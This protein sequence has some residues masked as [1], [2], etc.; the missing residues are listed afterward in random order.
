MALFQK[1]KKVIQVGGQKIVLE[2]KPSKS[3][4]SR[5]FARKPKPKPQPIIPPLKPSEAVHLEQLAK[6]PGTAQPPAK[7]ER[8]LFGRKKPAPTILG[9]PT[10]PMEVPKLTTEREQP[11]VGVTKEEKAA[12]G[13]LVKE[14]VP[15]AQ[16]QLTEEERIRELEKTCL[17]YTSPSPR[18]PKTSRMPSSA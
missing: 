10:K 8:G 9:V 4:L 1:Q 11:T 13:Q 12:V 18:D 6:K 7:E 3:I 15:S 14:G 17:L 5:L 16:K 2:P